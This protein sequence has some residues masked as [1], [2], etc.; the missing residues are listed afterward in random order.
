[1]EVL[2]DTL[3]LLL[4]PF[5]ACLAITAL[6]GYVGLH[7]IKRGVIFVDLALAQCAALG[8]AV[9]L[10]VAPLIWT[11]PPHDHA[12]QN[13]GVAA[14]SRLAEQFE[15][16]DEDLFG[17]LEET[18]QAHVGFPKVPR[19]HREHETLTYALSLV[20]A[21]LGAV[22]LS[23]AR[24]RD[25]RIPHEAIIGIIFVVGASLSVLILSKA[26]HGH[27]KMEAMLVG[28]ILF[29]RWSELA[30]MLPLYLALGVFHILLR[31]P[32]IEISKDVSAAERSGRRVRLWD[33]LFYGS[34]AVLVT[35]SVSI[36]GVFVVFSYL[37]IPPACGALLADGFR[38]QVV[39]AWVLG[40]MTTIAGL[41][42]SA[43]GD[44]PTGSSL[45]S[46]F[47]AVL[48]LVFLIQPILVRR[49]IRSNH[50]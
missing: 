11:E 34:F 15:R 38:S 29:V 19:A 6:H 33:C 50:K 16:G 5:T 35:H 20:F 28:S 8:A 42:V 27:E 32:F 7:V 46:C 47:G 37:I 4:A 23:F 48:V 25:E 22:L 14:E 45:V 30:V 24:L 9:A 21:L 1:M 40:V 12:Q 10:L 26:P 3:P 41:V 18:G 17:A 36:A 44:M 31:K 2:I 49:R 39:V 13:G 43:V